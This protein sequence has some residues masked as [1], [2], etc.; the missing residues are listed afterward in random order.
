MGGWGG[1]G[2]CSILN[3][4]EGIRKSFTKGERKTDEAICVFFL[5]Q[6]NYFPSAPNSLSIFYIRSVGGG[7]F[8]FII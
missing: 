4:N 7:V 1:G 8:T 3:D 2:C 5:A 6:C